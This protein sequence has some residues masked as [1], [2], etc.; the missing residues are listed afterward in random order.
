MKTV[1]IYRLFFTRALTDVRAE[2]AAYEADVADWYENGDG[3]SSSE[4][5]KGYRYP[6][7]R[8]GVRTWVDYDCACWACEDGLNDFDMARGRAREAWLRFVARWDWLMSA[9]G[10]I[11]AD[12]RKSITDWVMDQLKNNIPE[13][14]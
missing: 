13:S 8:H 10:D 7:C 11:P 9:P 1:G 12:A 2:T 3:R 4:G 14:K 6:H 5:G